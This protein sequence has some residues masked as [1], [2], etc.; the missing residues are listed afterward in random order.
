MRKYRPERSVSEKGLKVM[1][2]KQL[3]DKSQYNA[4]VN[5]INVINPQMS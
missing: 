5:G 2:D 4:V 1:L 3:N